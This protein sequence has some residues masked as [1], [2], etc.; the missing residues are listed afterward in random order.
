[1]Y[2]GYLSKERNIKSSS[3]EEF[4]ELED[5]EDDQEGMVFVSEDVGKE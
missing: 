5:E 3:N 4:G 1:M 2:E